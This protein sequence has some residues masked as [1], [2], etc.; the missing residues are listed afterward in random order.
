MANKRASEKSTRQTA[1]RTIRNKSLR[2]KIKTLA[3]QVFVTKAS[4][5][6]SRAKEAAIEYISCLDKAVKVGVIHRNKVSRYKSIL[7]KITMS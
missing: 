2:S 7:A 6:D 3:K 1:T 4:G 5:V